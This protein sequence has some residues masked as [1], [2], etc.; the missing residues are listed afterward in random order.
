M[1]ASPA[2]PRLARLAVLALATLA[3]AAP[4]AW[5]VRA[6][7]ADA[8]SAPAPSGFEA[9]SL[10]ESAP[11]IAALA[12]P[13]TPTLL[14]RHDAN[15]EARR[16]ADASK[17]LTSAR[18]AILLRSLTVPGWGQATLGANRSATVFAVIEAGIWGSFIAFQVQDQLRT[19]SSERTALYLAG[20]DLR[21]RDEEFRRAVGSY[22]SSDEY[23]LFVVARDAANL[24]YDDPV[25][26]Q[27]YIDANSLK[28]SSTWNW[29]DVASVERYRAQR[30]NAHQAQQRANTTLALAIANRIVSA[31]HAARI[32]SHPGS[33]TH[34]WNIDVSPGVGDALACRV[35]VSTSF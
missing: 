7:H 26:M 32:A 6:A 20:I 25:K 12:S 23:N 3:M 4:C 21:G 18:A 27:A 33:K 10:S 28:G 35:G 29:K 2:R 8:G 11:L 22:L 31:L 9:T 19:R 14:A 5:G 17:A 16:E 13:L 15:A 24:Y 1:R 30:K 34:S